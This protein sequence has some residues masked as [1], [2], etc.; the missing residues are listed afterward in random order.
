MI[1]KPNRF[2]G[3]RL[4]SEADPNETTNDEVGEIYVSVGHIISCL[5]WMSFTIIPSG[6]R[7]AR[8]RDGARAR[9]GTVARCPG[10]SPI[11]RFIAEGGKGLYSE[12]E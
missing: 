5:R 1:G 12:R 10:D 8:G 7:I 4:N 6:I 11:D 3:M 2:H 9:L